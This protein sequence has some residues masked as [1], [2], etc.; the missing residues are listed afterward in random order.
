MVNQHT[1][2]TPRSWLRMQATRHPIRLF[3][4]LAFGFAYPLMFLVILAQRGVIPGGALPA[5]VGL[6]MERTASLLLTL[7]GLLPAAVL[8]TALEGGWPAVQALFSRSFR[9]RI[10]LVW[11]LVVVAAL[12]AMSIALAVLL[13]DTLRMPSAGVLAWEMVEIAVAFLLINLWEETAWTGFLQTRLERRHRFFVA[14]ALTVVPFAAIH[15]PLQLI[16]GNADPAGLAQAFVLYLILGIIVRPLF[17]IVLRGSGDSVMAAAL[18]HTFFNRSNNIDGIVAD[19]LAGP[20]RSLAALIATLLLTIVLGIAIR[21]RLTRAHRQ[22]LDELT[23]AAVASS[24]TPDT[25][26]GH[27]QV[28]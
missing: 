3:L 9:W 22:E 15:M 28:A 23:S 26:I 24:A 6:D 16:N 14:A 21:H 4:A 13:G 27:G 2:T 12:P 8:V 5:M 1:A 25:H 19:L 11:W 7:L 18:M 17:G 20:N 10:G